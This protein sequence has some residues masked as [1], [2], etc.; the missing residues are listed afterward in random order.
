MNLSINNCIRYVRQKSENI[1]I[2]MERYLTMSKNAKNYDIMGSRKGKGWC[3]LGYKKAIVEL[4]EKIHSPQIL[5]RIYK[6]VMY[7]YTQ[8]K[9]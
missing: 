3:P 1:S 7:L 2:I 6:F 8:E 5:K 9:D 4:V